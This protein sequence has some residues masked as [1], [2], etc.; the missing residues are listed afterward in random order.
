ME[1][2]IEENVNKLDLV[3]KDISDLKSLYMSIDELQKDTATKMSQYDELQ[4]Y[5]DL[6]KS[7]QHLE[8]MGAFLVKHGDALTKANEFI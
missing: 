3:K 4:K 1:K 2:E 7:M 6:M 5:A 8:R